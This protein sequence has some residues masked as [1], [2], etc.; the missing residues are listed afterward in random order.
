MFDWKITSLTLAVFI[1][2]AMPAFSMEPVSIATGSAKSTP[3]QPQAAIDSDGTVHLIFGDGDTVKYCHS[4]DGGKS[5]SVPNAAFEVPNISLGMRRGPRI[6]LCSGTITVSAIGGAQGKGRDG[7]IQAWN[8]KDGGKSWAGP[9]LVNDQTGSAREG[10]HA[11]CSGEDGTLWCVWLDLRNKRTEIFASNSS[12]AGTTWQPN[13]L[14]YRS[15]DRNVCECCHPSVAVRGNQV[16]VMFRNSLNGNR[17]MYLTTSTDGGATFPNAKKLGNG[18]WKLNACPMDGGM[19]ALDVDKNPLTV[20]TRKGS[21][22]M[23]NQQTEEE[24]LLGRGGQPWVASTKQ[25]PV[26]VWTNPNERSLY[27]QLPKSDE[28]SK[29]VATAIDPMVISNRSGDG[30]A[31]VFWETKIDGI[32]AIQGLP[33]DLK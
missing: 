6:A 3:K 2:T 7:D 29:M 10:L 18:E 12:D 33:L 31:F 21:V 13:Q 22:F 30:P 25:G 19:V 17:D 23:T 8:S 24:Q 27:L 16:T 5:F 15:P 9:F 11:M 14:V 4:S 28:P 26:A 32:N 20:W 1:A